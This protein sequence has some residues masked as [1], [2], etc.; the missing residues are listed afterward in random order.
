[1]YNFY[2]F[3]WYLEDLFCLILLFHL[4]FMI[5]YN[6]IYNIIYIKHISVL[7]SPLVLSQDTSFVIPTE[8]C[9]GG[10]DHSRSR[11]IGCVENVKRTKCRFEKAPPAEISWREIAS[12]PEALIRPSSFLVVARSRSASASRNVAD[13]RDRIYF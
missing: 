1:M 8:C 9:D 7:V 3:S 4:Q 5:L 11:W 12:F 10:G 2:F 6:C 13:G